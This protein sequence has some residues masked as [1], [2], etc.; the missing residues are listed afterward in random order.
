MDR[1]RKERREKRFQE[2]IEKF[3]QER[4]KIQQQFSDLKVGLVRLFVGGEENGG[5][6]VLSPPLSVSSLHT[7][8][9]YISIYLSLC[10]RVCVCV[11]HPREP[12]R[13]CLMMSGWVFPMSAM[14]ETRERGILMSVLTGTMNSTKVQ[15]PRHEMQWLSQRL[16]WSRV[17]L[18]NTMSTSNEMW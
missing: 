10:L 2:D 6:I 11:Y 1:R 14:P 16:L 3:R 18:Y 15:N 4:P 9:V 17:C 8:C 12:C 7:L 5:E 13:G